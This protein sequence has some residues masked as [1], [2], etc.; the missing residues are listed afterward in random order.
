[1]LEVETCK[2]IHQK[3]KHQQRNPDNYQ[4]VAK[5]FPIVTP[6][7]TLSA[8]YALLD[9]D[10]NVIAIIEA[11]NF[12]RSARD[13]EFQALEYAEHIE[14]K[15]GYRPFIF[16]SNGRELYFYHSAANQAPRKV[17]TF[18]TLSDLHRLKALHTTAF[19]STS[20]QVDANIAGRD[21]QIE[22]IK[23]VVE[24]LEQGKRKFLLVMATGTGKTRTAMG[25]IDVLLKTHTI[26]KVLFLTDRTALRNQAFDD[27]FKPFFP[28]EPKTKI[29]T[30][31]VDTSARLYSATYQTIINLLD[32]FSS[33]FFDLIIMDEVHRSIYREW[34]TILDYFDCY[35][36]GLTATPIEFVER[37][38]YQAFDCKDQGPTYDF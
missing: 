9:T 23:S 29:L 30:K 5:E 21:Y 38:T 3:L 15:Q 28:E 18:F 13:G 35:Q 7:T 27:G 8:D 2:F 33:G 17:K 10:G 37:N 36:V 12:S 26:Q 16:L 31:N 20:Q 19:P 22:A 14:D 25:L 34:K 1:M 11:K 4:Q 32:Q 6:E 24:K